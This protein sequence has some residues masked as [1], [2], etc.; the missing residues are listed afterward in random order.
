MRVG[1][2]TRPG[3]CEMSSLGLWDTGTRAEREVST[4]YVARQGRS[5]L[6]CRMTT[7]PHSWRAMLLETHRADVE[8]LS[9]ADFPV[10]DLGRELGL[11][12]PLFES[13][14]D[15]AAAARGELA[16]DIVLRVGI[17]EGD[18]IVIRLRHRT[19]VLDAGCA[20]R[21]AGYHITAL[22]W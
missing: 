16:E 4:G 11:T 12:Q 9:H 7:E 17:V 1:V 10:E 21:I 5:P 19:D 14:F 15:P 3:R 20:R 18:G 22:A 6:F 8:L 13:V 2:E